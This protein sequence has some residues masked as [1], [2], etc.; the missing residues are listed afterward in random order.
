MKKK[1]NL[2][3]GDDND[4]NIERKWDEVHEEYISKYAELRNEDLNYEKGGINGMFEKIGKKRG[5]SLS[6]IRNEVAS[7]R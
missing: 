1:K 6:E 5:K 7:W 3:I 2:H 4:Q